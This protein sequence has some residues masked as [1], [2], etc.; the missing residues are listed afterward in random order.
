M[1]TDEYEI[2]EFLAF[3]DS[4]APD[5][6]KLSSIVAMAITLAEAFSHRAKLSKY[7]SFEGISAYMLMHIAVEVKKEVALQA[8]E[9]MTQ[10][11]NQHEPN[12]KH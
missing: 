11:I 2:K 3:L 9:S 1:I 5:N 12:T 8:I 4:D 7:A 6:Q 10:M